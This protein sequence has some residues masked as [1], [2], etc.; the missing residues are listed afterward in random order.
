MDKSIQFGDILDAADQL[1][2][3]DQEV[4]LEVLRSRIIEQRREELL[5]EVREAQKE[6]KTGQVKPGTVDE[7]MR[8][9][10]T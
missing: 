2:L 10:S 1:S 5:S 9:I 7:I 8:D 6:Y 4:L 3:E